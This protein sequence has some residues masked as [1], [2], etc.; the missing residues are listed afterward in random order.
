MGIGFLVPAFLAGLTALLVPII[1]HLRHRE[2]DKPRR[3]PSLMFLRRIPIRTARRRRIT[4][5][6][7]LAIRAGVVAALVAAFTRPFLGKAAVTGSG[8][9]A[10]AVVL[11]LDR[12]LSMGHSAVWPA[13]IDSARAILTALRPA[14]RVA[15]VL[16]DEEAEVAAPFGNDGAAAL[17]AVRAARPVARGTR[18]AA[19][20]RAARQLLSTDQAKGRKGEVLVVT[21]LQRSGLSG[22][23]G[24]ELP[25]EVSVRAVPVVPPTRA[26]AAVI[27]A[28][29]Q[30][31]AE[32]DR[33]RLVVAAQVV[34]RDLGAPRTTRLSLTVNGRAAGSREVQLP[35][36]GGATVGFDPVP[37]PAGRV[38]AT[39]ALP[40][41]ALVADDSFHF[42]VPAEEGV[43]VVLVAPGDARADETLFLERALA[44][45]RAPRITVERRIGSGG[46]DARTLRGAGVV[47]LFDSPIPSNGALERWVR[48][49]GGL[50]VAAG[51]RLEA[52]R[53]GGAGGLLPGTIRGAIE[54]MPTGGGSA[55]ASGGGA[56]GEI[57]LDHP[58]F[59]A[60]KEGGGAALGSARF[61]RY[62]RVEPDSG[63]EVLAR[64][65]D[66]APAVLERAAGQGEVVLVTA[67][68]D[69]LTGDFPLQPAY[70]PFLR[71]LTL[72]A[73]G[74]VV[75][76]L[77]R[78]T[79]EVGMVP[80]S[81]REPVVRMP[82]GSLLRPKQDREVG[83]S[84][85]RT[86]GKGEQAEPCAVVL[87]DAGFYEMFEGKAAGEP[88]EILA[89][90]APAGESDLTPADAR[91]LLLGVRR[92]DSASTGSADLPT[93]GEQEGR[94]RIWRTL[95]VLVGLLLIVEM[96]VANRGW[97]ASASL[98]SAPPASREGSS[99]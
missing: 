89:A 78:E 42:V 69:G 85:G 45:G 83:Q 3:F 27:G 57:S 40:P 60:F 35:A 13:A 1:L 18:Y 6:V 96:M 50:I 74:H 97:R 10:R 15:V 29:V 44:I 91:E 32:G 62:A 80:P 2:R 21:D 70:L 92:S 23:A 49:G 5:W 38:Q 73:A 59:T 41:D 52:S 47:L 72:F 31:V 67:P 39:I 33:T 65:D 34:A 76:P 16:F 68:L 98:V 55:G 22:L 86:V 19:G 64:F 88:V 79:G 75:A 20:L 58:V 95:L 4:D 51:R 24:L 26:N 63:A 48:D 93:P 66:G 99:T 84:D 61:F 14:D 54:R 71:R 12:S 77:W 8:T 28:D 17:A 25:A 7:L 43:R 81:I 9:P 53:S 37:L 30:R 11:L 90:N 46:L 94:Q 36:D 87:G 82:G 56:F